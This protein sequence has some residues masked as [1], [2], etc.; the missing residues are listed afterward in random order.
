[1]ITI[2][3]NPRSPELYAFLTWEDAEEPSF[4]RYM[5]DRAFGRFDPPITSAQD[6]HKRSSHLLSAKK[7]AVHAALAAGRGR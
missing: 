5:F 1:M 2:P 7:A 4:T 6:N 3:L